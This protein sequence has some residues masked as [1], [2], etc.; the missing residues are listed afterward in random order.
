MTARGVGAHAGR[1]LDRVQAVH[2]GVDLLL[3]RG[4][5]GQDDVG[6]LRVNALGDQFLAALRL[7]LHR[8]AGP[9]HGFNLGAGQLLQ[10]AVSLVNLTSANRVDVAARRALRRRQVDREALFACHHPIKTRLVVVG[11]LFLSFSLAVQRPFSGFKW[12][13]VPVDVPGV[14][15]HDT[16]VLAWMGA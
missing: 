5:S 8:A 9:A 10:L 3:L 6:A 16:V 15:Q 13:P 14:I 12:M 11:R 2:H 7:A 1:H 4:T